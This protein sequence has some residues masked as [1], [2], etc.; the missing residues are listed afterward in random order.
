MQKFP[1]FLDLLALFVPKLPDEAQHGLQVNIILFV[2]LL[3]QVHGVFNRAHFALQLDEF[4]ADLVLGMHEGVNV[5][6]CH[7]LGA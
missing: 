7:F 3:H 2:A 5:L 4:V 1:N 6:G